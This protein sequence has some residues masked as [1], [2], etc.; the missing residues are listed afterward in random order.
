MKRRAASRRLY[1]SQLVLESIVFS[2]VPLFN[3][4]A[5]RAHRAYAYAA[6]AHALR[7][8]KTAPPMLELPDWV[9]EAIFSIYVGSPDPAIPVTESG[10]IIMALLRCAA[11]ILND[12]VV[13]PSYDDRG[14]YGYVVFQRELAPF[15]SRAST[16]RL[17]MVE[18][19][20][21]QAKSAMLDTHFQHGS[22]LRQASEHANAFLWCTLDDARAAGMGDWAIEALLK[23][24]GV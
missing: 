13:V 17:A 5:R 14:Y 4:A 1:G 15:H 10:S 11:L 7:M 24:Y 6:P 8:N 23:R 9:E 22:L 20:R 16:P 18:A 21:A 12:G 2:L 3:P 19:R